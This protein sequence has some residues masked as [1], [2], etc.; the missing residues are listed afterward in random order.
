MDIFK[1][2]DIF[3][4]LP[5]RSSPKTQVKKTQVNKNA[6]ILKRRQAMQEN[7]IIVKQKRRFEKNKKSPNPRTQAMAVVCFWWW[8]LWWGS[9]AIKN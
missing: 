3:C 5:K 4:R 2:T 7:K 6:G 9:L 8:S 1:K